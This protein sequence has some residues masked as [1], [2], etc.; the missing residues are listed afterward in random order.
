MRIT[1]WGHAAFAATLIALG[2]L[3]LIK[4]DFA[5]NLPA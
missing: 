1:S 2:L 5:P 4:G 3:S